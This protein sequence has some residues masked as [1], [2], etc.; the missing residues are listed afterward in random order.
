MKKTFK[1]SRYCSFG[2][3]QEWIALFFTMEDAVLSNSP[4]GPRQKDALFYYLQDLE[5]LHSQKNTTDLFKRLLT[6]YKAEGIN[7]CFMWSIFWIT[8]SHN[9]LL[10]EWWN[11][12]VAQKYTRQE[13]ITSLS[14]SYEKMNR[15]V[16]NGYQSLVG[17]LE[18]TPI[19]KDLKQGRV[20][21]EGRSRIVIKEGT[22]ELSP[23]AI[24]YALYKLAQQ[25]HHFRI[26]I[27]TIEHTALSPQQI[28]CMATDKVDSLLRSL[29]LPDLFE[30]QNE[31]GEVCVRLAEEKTALDVLNAYIQRLSH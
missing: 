5:L 31:A 15:S 16:G 27:N 18:R 19:G 23:F 24:L 13:I 8:L 2:L 12:K 11:K 1:L 30:L 10:F 22:P 7:S 9:V 6:I 21:K 28:F 17:T 29:W 3:R 14:N 26:N 20:Q 4:L 25:T